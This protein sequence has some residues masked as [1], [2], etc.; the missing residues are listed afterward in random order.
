MNRFQLLNMDGTEDD[1]DD[2]EHDTS[3]MSLP[4]AMAS[5]TLGVLA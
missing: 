5:S 3:G 4:T 2:D 1:S